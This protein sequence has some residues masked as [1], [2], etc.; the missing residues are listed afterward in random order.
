MTVQCHAREADRMTESADGATRRP[1]DLDPVEGDWVSV[2]GLAGGIARMRA[3][4]RDG[5]LLVAARGHGEP[6]PGDWG[7]TEAAV[8]ANALRSTAGYAFVATFDGPPVR[9][10]L[11]TYQ[12]LGVLVVHAFHRYTDG[13]GR[14]DYF[15]REFYV[16][17]DGSG[18]GSPDARGSGGGPPDGAGSPA[19]LP[20]ELLGGGN[21]PAALI[22]VW[23]GLAP[24][25]TRSIGV[26]E[27]ARSGSGLTVRAE[28]VGAD[29]PVDW[30]T[31]EAHLYADAHHLDDPPAFLATFDHGYMRVRLQVRVNRGVLVVGEYTTFT[32]GSGRSDYFI[33]ECYRR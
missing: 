28:G 33:R 12:G 3:R 23:R 25:A 10:E 1:L 24:A 26:L 16:P 20:R 14:R 9:S 19:T 32:D 15:T 22:G 30:G 4:A 29:G 18:A 17:P 8:F 31:A 27:C 11:Q 21:D 7:E 2:T 6:R 13:S 5:A